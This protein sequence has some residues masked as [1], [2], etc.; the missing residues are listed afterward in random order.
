[1]NWKNVLELNSNILKD[2]DIGTLQTYWIYLQCVKKNV[3][4]L[5]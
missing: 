5:I 2:L 1:M 3:V 4:L